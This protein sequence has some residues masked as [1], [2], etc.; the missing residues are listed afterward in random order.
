MSNPDDRTYTNGEI[1][2]FW[3]P[4]LC[5]HATICFVKLRKVF[6]PV[7]RPWVNMDGAPT[8]EIISIVDECPTDALSWKFNN[9]LTDAEVQQSTIKS[10]K[11]ERVPSP[12]PETEITVVENGP[13]IIRGNFKVVNQAGKEI[14]TTNQAALCRCGG[15]RNQ[16][17]C[18][19]SHLINRFKG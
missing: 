4:D 5:I 3:K 18:D 6:N 7:K 12:P 8:D 2:V 1:T 10:N 14:A 13:A 9:E 16:P 17:F 11:E 19:G 15:S